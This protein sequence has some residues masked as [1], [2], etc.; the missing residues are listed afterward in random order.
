MNRASAT[1]LTIL[2]ATLAAW[3]LAFIG[4][5][6]A[7]D[8]PPGPSAHP[9]TVSAWAELRSGSS[10]MMSYTFSFAVSLIFAWM[11]F[12][13]RNWLL[14]LPVAASLFVAVDIFRWSAC[15]LAPLF[16]AN[17]PLRP[18]AFSILLVLCAELMLRI[19]NAKQQEPDDV[20]E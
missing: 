9:G 2:A 8:Y 7:L 1:G 3:A 13:T 6:N 11:L 16:P 4:V 12:R 10:L 20:L 18:V 19:Y 15:N 17:D 5:W 14:V